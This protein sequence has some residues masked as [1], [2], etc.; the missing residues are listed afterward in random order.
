MRKIREYEHILEAAEKWR[1][2]CLLD[3]RSLFTDQSLWTQKN[4]EELH[5]LYVGNPDDSED[6]FMVKLQRQLEP[7]TP[8]VKCLAAEMTWVYRLIEEPKG[9]KSATKRERI[10][11]IWGWSRRDFPVDHELLS[12]SVLGAGTINTG[13]AYNTRIWKEY[14]FF[15]NSMLAWFTRGRSERETLLGDPDRFAN[16]LDDTKEAAN[17]AFRH[18][19]LFLL[20]SKHFEPIVSSGGKKQIVDKLYQGGDRPSDAIGIDQA[21]R[22]VRKQL[23]ENYPKGFNFYRSPVK[24]LWQEE[25]L[26]ERPATPIPTRAINLAEPTPTVAYTVDAGHDG[27]FIPRKT[28]VRIIDSIRSRKNLVLQGPPGTG[29]TYMARRIAWCVTER[30]DSGLIKLVQFHQS[31]SY[32][33]FVQGYRPSKSGGFKLKNGVFYNFCEQARK[34]ELPHVFIIDEIN[35]GNL[36][37]IFGEL[38]MLIEEDKRNKDY[39]V[40]LTYSPGRFHVPENVYILGMMNTADRSLAVVD[41]ALRRRFSFETLEPAFQTEYGR[42]ELR[43]YLEA[44]GAEPNLVARIFDRMG[45][46]NKTIRGDKELGAGFQ[47]GHSYFIPADG[48]DPSEDWYERTVDTQI[49]PLLQEYWFDAPEKVE[50]QIAKLKGD[51]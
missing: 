19:M 48:E 36:S 25:E 4:F 33:D 30:K 17:R 24:E 31:Y 16:W 5:T 44:K 26:P 12:D 2:R 13:T 21:L 35:R 50:T 46:L 23:E 27:L 42:S 45:K 8:D 1:S 15:V 49:A 40:A 11:E 38:L 10:Q 18:A 28:F 51:D 41:Y 32:E 7:G 34:S 20:F 47:I 6:K 29:K 43:E 39:A 22:I 37:R 14:R 9:M 3:E